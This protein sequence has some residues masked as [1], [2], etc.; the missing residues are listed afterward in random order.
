M[1]D[2]IFVKKLAGFMVVLMVLFGAFYANKAI[3]GGGSNL[4]QQQQ[5]QL[6]AA[7]LAAAQRR[8]AGT[9]SAFDLL[10]LN[11]GAL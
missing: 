1:K 9:P 10:L 8:A 2:K 3:A 6:L 7:Q 4:S 11:Y 5:Q